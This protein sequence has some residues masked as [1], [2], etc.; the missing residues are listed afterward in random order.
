MARPASTSVGNG[1]VLSAI[2]F[3]AL[4]SLLS[5]T[6]A[7]R[8]TGHWHRLDDPWIWGWMAIAAAM[9]GFWG[10]LALIL[11]ATRSTALGRRLLVG[12]GLVHLTLT[13]LGLRDVFSHDS[14][15]SI[16]FQ[17]IAIP[18]ISTVVM[19]PLLLLLGWIGKAYGAPDN[20]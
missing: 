2:C 3:F 5:Y 10:Y 19:G 11:D 15:G 12:L 20:D 13:A 17:A 6:N 7:A 18:V 1:V 8:G 14:D 4:T 9:F 16:A